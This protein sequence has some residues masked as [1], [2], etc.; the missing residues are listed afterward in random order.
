MEHTTD[1]AKSKTMK[2]ILAKQLTTGDRVLI[3]ITTTIA[4]IVMVGGMV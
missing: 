3:A 4:I 2:D 1:Y